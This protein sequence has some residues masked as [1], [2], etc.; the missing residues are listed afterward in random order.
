MY[1]IMLEL[2]ICHKHTDTYFRCYIMYAQGPLFIYWV[3]GAYL[4]V[5]SIQ[6]IVFVYWIL[7]PAT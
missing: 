4:T 7:V 6:Y 5:L 3:L 1:S 2:S